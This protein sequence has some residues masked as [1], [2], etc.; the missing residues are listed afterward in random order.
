MNYPNTPNYF[1]S[2]ITQGNPANAC[3]YGMA[4][5][6]GGMCQISQINGYGL[7]TLGFIWQAPEIWFHPQAMD[8]IGP[9]GASM[10]V[11]TA[12]AGYRDACRLVLLLLLGYLRKVL[13]VKLQYRGGQ[14]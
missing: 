7:L 1:T 5:L 4:Q 14:G 10:T 11:W 2:R 12:A 6:D 13:E 9:N 8:G 3:P